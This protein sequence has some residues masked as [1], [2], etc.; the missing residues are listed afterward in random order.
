MMRWLGMMAAAC[1][2]LPNVVQAAD[3]FDA[4]WIW[5]GTENPA[6]QAPQGK[7]W[8]RRQVRA[9]E[10][11]TG[12]VR[13]LCDDHFVLWVNGRRV[14]EGD[15]S[16]IHRFN[17]NGIVD[18]GINVIAV[19][20]TNRGGAAGLFVDG[21]VRGQSGRPVP[22]DTGPAWK[23]S[24]SAPQGTAW[25]GPDF[26]TGN[27]QAVTVIGPH[28]KSPWNELELKETYLDRFHLA[29]GFE[30]TR[31]AEPDLVGSLVAIT[32]GNRGRLIA[33][34]ERGPILSVIDADQNGIFDRVVEYS[35]Q[36]TNCQGLCMVGDDLYAVGNGPKGTGIYRLPD[37][38]R[39]DVA[40]EVQ[41][42]YAHKGGIGEHGP[43]DIVLGPDGWLYHNTGNHAWITATPEPTTAVRDS[44]EGYLLQPK[45]E[46]ARGHARGIPAPGGTIWRFTPDGKRWWC[47]TAGFRNEYD[48]AFNQH[49]EL[50]SFDSD[51]EWDVG[52]PWYRPIRVNHCVPGA[53]FGWRSG[54]GKWPEYYFDSLPGAVDIGRG[55][56]TGVVFYEHQQFPAKYHGA[57][58]VC[59]WSMGR[60]MAVFLEPD[61]ATYTG[62]FENLVTGNP[63]NVSD[64]EVDRDGSVIFSTGGRRTEGGLYRVTSSQGPSV[65]PKAD[66]IED[67]FQLPQIHAAWAREAARRI[68]EQ[69]GDAWKA[70]LTEK[71]RN[72][73]PGEQ[74]RALTLLSQLGPKP[75][76][77]LLIE[78]AT[79]QGA[80]SVRAFATHLLGYHSG[81]AVAQTLTR[82]LEDPAPFVCRRACEAFVRSGLQPPIDRLLRLMGDADR[83]IRFSARLA[84]ERVPVEHWRHQVLAARNPDVLLNGLLAL[85]RLGSIAPERALEIESQLLRGRRGVL[86]PPAAVDALRMVQLSLIAAESPPPAAEAIGQH[87]LE[88]FPTGRIAFD[89]E[90]ARILAFLDAPEAA[91]KILTAM[92]TAPDKR[93]QIHYA[94]T[95]RYLDAGW[96][97]DRKRRLL[98]WYEKT[99]DWEGG[100]SFAPYLANIVGASL[101]RFQP[102]ERRALIA[103]WAAR[104]F[105]TGLL[106]Q[107][108]RPEQIAD[109][110]QVLLALFDASRTSKR[111][112]QEE[113]VGLAIDTL[114]RSA[115]PA[116]KQLLRDLYETHPDRR[117]QLARAIA[118]HP[119]AEDWDQ[120]IR[121][122]RFA[123]S[124]TLQLCISA[125]RKIDRKPEN[126]EPVRWVILAGLKLG[127]RGGLPAAALLQ[128]W[129]GSP[130]K[131]GKNAVAAIAHYQT[132]FAEK[133]PD[134]PPAE[135]PQADPSQSKYS[136]QQLMAFL[137]DNP[138]GQRGDVERGRKIFADAKC[139]KCHRFENQGETIG[140]DLTS[141]RRRFQKKEIIESLVYPSQVISDQYRMVT[142]VTADGLVH[143]GMPV[144]GN[145]NKDRVVLLLSDATRLEI[146]RGD[147]EEMVP[148]KLSVMPAGLL[149]DLTLA[150]IADLFAFLE[151][152]K[153]NEVTPADANA[154]A[155]GE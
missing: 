61:G 47:E 116:A 136:F 87:L 85:H 31:I 32:W 95:L 4:H 24:L 53:E 89:M 15:A 137:E 83:W 37:R 8:F 94:L 92:E 2:A 131:S 132:W 76:T 1:L 106:L 73:A 57:L 119:T 33:S 67:L 122:L 46:D 91:E 142:V 146:P 134:A 21:E 75:E 120:L 115:A 5:S 79:G 69:S 129:T 7:V 81:D 74:L 104:P 93:S 155:A 108:S 30:L 123:D 138:Q 114:S 62:K 34:R 86:P 43:H 70:A 121:T 80:E 103:S 13:I 12:G 127:N 148:S 130:H 20:A 102:E 44:Y 26:D 140:P 63:L 50:F 9:T 90:A 18:R 16:R 135:L 51:M 10:P 29:P 39:D 100:N 17:L 151:T 66:S 154:K 19:E 126:P 78:L 107:N 54:A 48:I 72:G 99:R 125:L 141:L 113:M 42:V 35:N 144:P 11:S 105:A 98:D 27:W 14:G 56:P 145:P 128:Q 38:N 52:M 88:Q 139:S 40:D 111:P 41:H 23:A 110:D 77:D 60:I 149:N 143:N 153:F 68:Q 152:S 101:E 82:L 55:S 49:G 6:A 118:Q 45:F 84:L 112:G 22:F 59:D 65:L 36:V 25:L 96:N 28:E 147:I 109:F 97:F 58:L 150:Q 3:S 124:T 133:F 71:A 117:G 64:I